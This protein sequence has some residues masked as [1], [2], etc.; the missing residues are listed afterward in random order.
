MRKPGRKRSKYVAYVKRRLSSDARIIVALLR[1][2]PLGKDELC[3]KAGVPLSTFYRICRMLE[4]L[5]IL[6]E[7][8]VGGYALWSY[9]E[10]EKEIRATHSPL[11]S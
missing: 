4:D 10:I 8:E 7:I 3:K 9:S 1:K 5:G 11:K 2:Q 6:K